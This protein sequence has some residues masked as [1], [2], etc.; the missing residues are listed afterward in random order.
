MLSALCRII[1]NTG[2]RPAEEVLLME[3][4]HVNLTDKVQRYKGDRFQM[5]PPRSIF[6]ANGK[7]GTTQ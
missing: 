1:L 6:V 3:K 2:L 7:D 4:D 5:I